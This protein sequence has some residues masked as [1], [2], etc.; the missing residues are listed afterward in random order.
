[1]GGDVVVNNDLGWESFSAWECIALSDFV[2]MLNISKHNVA[3]VATLRSWLRAAAQATAYGFPDSEPEPQA[4]LSRHDG[5]TRLGFF[6]LGLGR[7]AALGRAMH[8]TTTNKPSRTQHG[9]HHCLGVREVPYSI[10]F[11]SQL[12][13]CIPSLFK[14]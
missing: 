12:T 3:K 14:V 13:N 7:L 5:L 2:D 9:H 11:S 8:I 6:G 10:I 1:V 4:L